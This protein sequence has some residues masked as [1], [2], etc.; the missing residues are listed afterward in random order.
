M[1]EWDWNGSVA[2]E[3]SCQCS[4]TIQM[5]SYHIAILLF[6]FRYQQ[7][8]WYYPT[9]VTQKLTSSNR[10]LGDVKGDILVKKGAYYDAYEKDIAMVQVRIVNGFR[11]L[12]FWVFLLHFTSCLM[13]FFFWD[14]TRKVRKTYK[15]QNK[16]YLLLL[17]L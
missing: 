13:F 2:P 12:L 8:I 3:Q 1:C 10:Y 6:H 4:L 11:S 14:K 16:K 5:V 17:V 7:R 15:K 9:F